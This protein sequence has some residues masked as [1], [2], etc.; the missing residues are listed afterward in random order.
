MDFIRDAIA[1]TEQCLARVEQILG[2]SI[3][4][5]G[6]LKWEGD[7]LTSEVMHRQIELCV[8]VQ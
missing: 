1:T 5:D 2:E 6:M 7:W 4:E 8:L 3:V